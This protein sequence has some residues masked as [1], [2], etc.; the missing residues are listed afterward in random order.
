MVVAEI[1]SI[2]YFLPIFSFLLVFIL[3]YAILKKTAI[4]GDSNGVLLFISLILASFFIVN[5]KMVE[6]VEFSSSWFVVFLVCI[7]F[8]L[9]FLAF[10]SKDYLKV[11][12]ENK[13]FA[14][15][16][17]AVLI[18]AFVVSAARIF[19]WVL[20]WDKIQAWFST[21]W[22]GMILL[23]AV[24]GVVAWVLSKK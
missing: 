10:V 4:L 15:I 24:A 8:I 23:L 1:G 18:I 6:F 12:T 7:L 11:F 21:D 2:S 22:F 3:V 9:M 20:E 5:V 13:A 19:N 16:F 17:L 14:L